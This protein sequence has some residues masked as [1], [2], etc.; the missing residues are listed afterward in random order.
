MTND[1]TRGNP[2]KLIFRFMIPVLIGNLFQQ[3][4]NM[5]DMIIVGRT[6][7]PDALA[8]VG[9]TGAVSFLIIGFISGLTGG[10]S[11]VT[12]QCFGAKNERDIKRSVGTT[13]ILSAVLTV[14]ITII[15]V[16]VIKPLL[17]AMKTPADILDY[18]YDY[19][20]MICWGLAATVFYNMLSNIVRALGDSVTPLI[21]LVVASVINVG[22]DFWFIMGLKM[23][24]SGAALATVLSQLLSGVMCLVFMLIK[25]PILRLK[26]ADFI[27]S[28]LWCWK[29]LRIGFPMAFQ[30]SITAIG[31]MVQQMAINK[32]GTAVVTA[33]SAAN[34]IDNFA[35]QGMF[36]LGTAMAVFCGQNWGANETKR[37]K[38]GVK[39]GMIICVAMAIF[40]GGIMIILSRPLTALFMTNVT[41]E[42]LQ[43]STKFLMFQASCYL[44]LGAIFVYRNSLQG[45]GY[46]TVTMLAGVTELVM[47]IVASLVLVEIIGF[48]GVCLSNPLAWVG[49]G[50]FLMIVY[51]I[52]MR[53]FKPKGNTIKVQ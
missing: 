48:T 31:V 18:S 23:G 16:L 19:I 33:Y 29:H 15:S 39:C 34:K 6:I 41:E 38:D 14:F 45:M 8:G 11:V 53:K 25:F 35:T 7:G 13:I 52:V 3:L 2:A 1:L 21:F 40:S 50:V 49:A 24:V 43:L 51:Y 37:I 17:I 46:S 30:F 4:Y 22:L 36:S 44:G 27:T 12:S 20:V 5:V 32:L 28:R 26:A 9:A 10:F 42:I 47:R